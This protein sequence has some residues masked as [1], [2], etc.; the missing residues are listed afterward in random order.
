MLIYGHNIKNLIFGF[1]VDIEFK[2][3]YLDPGLFGTRTNLDPG[4]MGAGTWDPGPAP[5]VGLGVQAAAETHTTTTSTLE[6]PPPRQCGHGNV[7]RQD[8][9]ECVATFHYI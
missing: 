3:G 6:S 8:C 4:L 7:L 1:E 5:T 9:P 2:M